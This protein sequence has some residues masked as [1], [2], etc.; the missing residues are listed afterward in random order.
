MGSAPNSHSVAGSENAS[1][2]P[3]QLLPPIGLAEELFSSLGRQSV[4]AGA[5]I[6][7]RRSPERSDPA[8]ILEPMERGVERTVL[9]LKNI[10]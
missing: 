1:D 3:H 7:L 9:D 5:T 4:I 8:P 2:R 6:V 10:F